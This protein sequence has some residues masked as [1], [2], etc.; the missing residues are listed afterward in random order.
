MFFKRE[1][2]DYMEAHKKRGGRHKAGAI[3]YAVKTY[4]NLK[5]SLMDCMGEGY[6]KGVDPDV[7]SFF[8]WSLGHGIVSL[9]IRNRAPFPKEPTKELAFAGIDLVHRL[10]ESTASHSRPKKK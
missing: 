8:H 6:L 10:V 9:A 2:K 5:Q 7:A 3:D 4:E 1:P